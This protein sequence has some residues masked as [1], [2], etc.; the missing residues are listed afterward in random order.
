[1]RAYIYDDLP[2]DQRLAHDSGEEVSASELNSLGVLYY[3]ATSLDEVNALAQQRGYKNRDEIEVSPSALGE[4]Y[5]TKVRSFFTEHL[6]EDEEIRYVRDGRGYF[7]V[8]DKQERWVRIAVEKDDLLIL[9]AGIYHRF[10]TDES[11]AMRLF[12]EEPKWTPLN[13]SE[14]L[15]DN[16]YRKEYVATYLA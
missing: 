6:H 13:R 8:R 14:E 16:P 11:N 10:T 3:K 9:P 7:D 5:E 1:M 15:N 2:G 12:K 4:S